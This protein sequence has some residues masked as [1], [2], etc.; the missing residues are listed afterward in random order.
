M[1]KGKTIT[2]NISSAEDVS[3]LNRATTSTIEAFKSNELVVKST[4]GGPS[5]FVRVRDLF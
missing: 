1:I 3:V 2:L 4:T 5:T